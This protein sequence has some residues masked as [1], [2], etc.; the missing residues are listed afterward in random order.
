MLKGKI[1]TENFSNQVK[2][3]KTKKTKKHFLCG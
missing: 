1:K 2:Y 3:S